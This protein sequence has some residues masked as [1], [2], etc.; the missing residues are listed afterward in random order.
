[1]C[2]YKSAQ[3]YKLDINPS[4]TT[5]YSENCQGEGILIIYNCKIHKRYTLE[6]ICKSLIAQIYI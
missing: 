5:Q 4:K 6:K 2:N 3:L 1:M